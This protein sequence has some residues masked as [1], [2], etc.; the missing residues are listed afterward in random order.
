MH[1]W[2]IVRLKLSEVFAKHFS[3]YKASSQ[4]YTFNKTS[5]TDLAPALTPAVML[6]S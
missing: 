4:R 1:S 5:S 3:V 2:L 6:K